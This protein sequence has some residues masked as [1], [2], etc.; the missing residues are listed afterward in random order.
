MGISITL[1]S[2]ILLGITL[3]GLHLFLRPLF[4]KKNAQKALVYLNDLYQKVNTFALSQKDRS[5]LN[6][7]GDH[8]I[9]GEFD[10][11]TILTLVKIAA[12]QVNDVLVD[13]GCGGGKVI[14][15]LSLNFT[16]KKAVGY[17]Y[18]PSLYHCCQSLKKAIRP[19][20]LPDIVF[21]QD[22]FFNADLSNA[23]IIIVN[24][25]G[26]R[27]ELFKALDSCLKHCPKGARIIITSHTLPS[28]P[29]KLIHQGIYPMSWG[30]CHCYVYQKVI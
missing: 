5:D 15:S 2:L 29:F 27:G 18:L 22:N 30:P 16:F 17:E 13:L 20:G 3:K 8:W 11:Y 4:F 28:I 21:Y 26:I 14:F 1:A 19:H 25:T 23:N 9:Y 24:A 10:Y 7:Q 6:L 12:P